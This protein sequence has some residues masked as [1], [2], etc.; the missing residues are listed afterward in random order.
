MHTAALARL[1]YTITTHADAVIEFHSIKPL[2]GKVLD[3]RLDE[4]FN[5]SRLKFGQILHDPVNSV[6][7]NR[8][9]RHSGQSNPQP[10]FIVYCIELCLMHCDQA[11]HG[12]VT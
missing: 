9:V 3:H 10:L 6:E 12:T 11:L 4:F 5:V 2:S 1:R 7:A 8:T